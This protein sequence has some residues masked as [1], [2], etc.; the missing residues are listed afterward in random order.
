MKLEGY[1]E[2]SLADVLEN[3]RDVDSVEI[4]IPVDDLWI[5]IEHL[6][7]RGLHRSPLSA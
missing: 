6:I 3:T 5:E 4:I 1:T 2:A 7:F